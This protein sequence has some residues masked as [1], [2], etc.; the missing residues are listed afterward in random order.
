MKSILHIQDV[1]DI[2]IEKE[3][4][5]RD[6][7]DQVA[8]HFNDDEI[9]AIFTKLRDWEEVHIQKFS[10]IRENIKKNKPHESYPGEFESYL[11]ALVDDKLYQEVSPSVFRN[12]IKDP[13]DAI[14]Y[15]IGFE[16][17]AILLFLELIP[18][19]QED[20]IS[21]IEQLMEEER[22]HIQYLNNLK[23]KLSS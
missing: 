7:Y 10:L 11:R 3:K 16:K 22:H 8:K 13:L 12:N 19:V 15:G 21:V 18:F 2:G 5:R 4:A 6:F 9:K 20:N 17:D 14:N 1:V 23:N